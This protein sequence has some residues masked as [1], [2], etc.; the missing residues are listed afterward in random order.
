[1]QVVLFGTV[2]AGLVLSNAAY[3]P[4]E[5]FKEQTGLSDVQYL[6]DSRTATHV[7][8]TPTRTLHAD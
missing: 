7:R 3:E 5:G 4:L 8:T 6:H 1:M 2:T